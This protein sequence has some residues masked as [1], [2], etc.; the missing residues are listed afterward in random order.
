MA[1]SATTTGPTRRWIEDWEPEDPVFWANRGAAIARRNLVTSIF[2]EHIG[3]SVWSLW[4]VLAL[5]MVPAAGF[6]VS[7]GQKFLL[8]SVATLVGAVLRVPY[9]FAVGRF[10]GRDWTVASALMLL[11]PALLA[12]IVLRVPGAPFWTLLLAAALSGLGGG[13]FASS[14][15]NINAFYRERDKGRALGLNAGGGNVGVATVQLV[16]L[17]VLALATDRH[18]SYVALVY[19]PLILMAA[20]AALRRMDNLAGMRIDGKAQARAI[21]DRHGIAMSV[22]YIGTF[23]SFIGYGFAFGLVLQYDFGRTPTQAAALT[24]IGPL[25]GSLTRPLGGALADRIGGARVTLWSFVAMAA[26][27]G[28]ILVASARHSLA[29]FVVAFVAVFVLSGIGNGSTYKVIPAIFEREAYARIGAGERR[30]FAFADARRRSGALLGIV[31]A[32]GAFGGVLIN[33]AF[34]ESYT[35]DASAMPAF[36]GFLVFYVVCATI[37]YLGYVRAPAR[38]T[39]APALGDGNA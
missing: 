35:V 32:V 34:R 15:T 10:G 9:T 31:G 6:H 4:S 29:L 14:M 36:V 27:T 13:N 5:F 33:L 8:T 1:D 11:V 17:L 38:A 26:A 7:A 12:V 30:S 22:L 19:V 28:I 21:R 2:A 24:F 20:L 3:F 25:L 37:T 16:G 23:G 18:P 39:P